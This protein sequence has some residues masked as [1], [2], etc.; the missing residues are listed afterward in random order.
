M[1]YHNLGDAEAAGANASAE[2][3]K[4]VMKYFSGISTEPK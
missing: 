4:S 1:D 3:P 2:A